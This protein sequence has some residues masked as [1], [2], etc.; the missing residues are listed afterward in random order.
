MSRKKRPLVLKYT[1]ED[2]TTEAL[3][4]SEVI[5]QAILQDAAVVHGTAREFDPR[6]VEAAKKRLRFVAEAAAEKELRRARSTP[7]ADADIEAALA[8]HSKVEDAAAELGITGRQI[9]N[10]KKRK[11]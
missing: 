10:R 5:Y 8:K 7:L 6:T 9:L 11:S 3:K 2:G 4:L 1:F